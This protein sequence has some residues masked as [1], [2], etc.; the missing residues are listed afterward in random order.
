[1]SAVS[2]LDGGYTYHYSYGGAGS[3][4]AWISSGTFSVIDLSAG[5]NIY[6][7]AR[8]HGAGHDGAYGYAMV[9]PVT[10]PR[11]QVRCGG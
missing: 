1:M 5:P 7:P 11:L 8:A 4:A 3:A 6:G 10:L 9:M 2:D